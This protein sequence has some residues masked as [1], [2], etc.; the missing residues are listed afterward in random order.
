M[1]KVASTRSLGNLWLKK[2]EYACHA[3]DTDQ[4]KYLNPIEKFNGAFISNEPDIQV[5]QLTEQ[6]KYLVMASDGMWTHL[7]RS[8]IAD[9]VT[10]K[11][12]S[13]KADD[14]DTV[15]LVRR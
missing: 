9:F 12:Q 8:E 6:D 15:W 11:E 7:R 3:F 2:K 5:V 13:L 14:K 4:T 1:G 10:K